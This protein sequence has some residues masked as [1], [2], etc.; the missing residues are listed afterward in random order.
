MFVLTYCGVFH[1]KRLDILYLK[2]LKY[3]DILGA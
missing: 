3:T 1:Y 2:Y